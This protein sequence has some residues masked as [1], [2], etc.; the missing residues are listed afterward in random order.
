MD[1]VELLIGKESVADQMVMFEPET[2]KIEKTIDQY[3]SGPQRY[4]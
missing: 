4:S 3:F 2:T 1:Q